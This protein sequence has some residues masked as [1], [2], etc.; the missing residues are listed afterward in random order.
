M[1]RDSRT[2]QPYPSAAQ[3]IADAPLAGEMSV[4]Y[5][6]PTHITPCVNA[7]QPEYRSPLGTFAIIAPPSA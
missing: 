7:K 1:L 4:Q 6:T 5:L 3:N 2:S